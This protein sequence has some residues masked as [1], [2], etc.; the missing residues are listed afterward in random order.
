MKPSRNEIADKSWNPITGCKYNC[1]YCKAK[2]IALYFSG[3]VRLN[4]ASPQCEHT[5]SGCTILESKFVSS[6]GSTLSH[7][8]RFRPTYHRYRLSHPKETKNGYN[9]LV[10]DMGEIFGEWIPDEW[11][12]EIMDACIEGYWNNYLFLTK[13]PKRYLELD[14]KGILPDGE[15]FWY[16]VTITKPD[17]PIV[18]LA[19]KN[20]WLNFEP[21]RGG[22]G[23]ELELYGAAWVVIGADELK[24]K[25]NIKPRKKWIVEIAQKATLAGIPVFM[26]ENL[27]GIV[28]DS[29]MRKE[30]PEKLINKYVKENV[31]K[32]WESDCMLCKTHH[33][34]NEMIT[35]C[36]KSKRSENAKQ[37]GFLCPECFKKQCGM[38][39][40]DVPELERWKDDDSK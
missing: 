26:K 4:M 36:A 5:E 31:R 1:P 30:L 29:E 34:K 19:G 14:G 18:E 7:P 28:G 16:G 10:G 15:N 3:D 38:W 13:N 39:G 35:I 2:K 40:I 20:V 23:T 24:W 22:F 8:F 12:K 32:M 25:G 6:S 17:D 9:V 37:F 11:I 33:K 27:R 21:L